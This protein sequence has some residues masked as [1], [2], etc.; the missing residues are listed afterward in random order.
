MHESSGAVLLQY[1]NCVKQLGLSTS[2]TATNRPEQFLSMTAT[3]T[4]SALIQPDSS[5]N[6]AA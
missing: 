5:S 2:F 6:K 1:I 4:N 3:V